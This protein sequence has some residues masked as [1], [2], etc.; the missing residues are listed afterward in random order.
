MTYPSFSAGE[1]LRAADMNAVGLWLVKTQAVGT[2]VSSVTVTGAFSADYDN[3]RIIYE[4]GV[5]SSLNDFT[6]I[7]G[8]TV[9]SYYTNMMYSYFNATSPTVLNS[10]NT[11]SWVYVGGA[12]T[13]NTHLEFD[14]F[15]PF[16]TKNTVLSNATWLQAA[17]GGGVGKVN[18]YLNNT[19]SYT[20]F[21]IAVANAGTTIT[22]G[23]IRVYGYRN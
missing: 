16:A 2:G 12:T 8:S 11:A 20:G 17:P 21:T 18:G 5:S 6:V 22:G 15:N 10:A 3:Y 4:G 9:S 1:V 23:T 14:L 19:T 13:G 7:L